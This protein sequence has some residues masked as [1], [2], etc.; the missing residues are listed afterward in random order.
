MKGLAELTRMNDRD[1]ARALKRRYEK[2]RA[3]AIKREDFVRARRYDGYVRDFTKFLSG[4]IEVFPGPRE[5]R[6]GKITPS[7]G[8]DFPIRQEREIVRVV[9]PPEFKERILRLDPSNRTLAEHL[10]AGKP[11][12][13]WFKIRVEPYAD[14]WQ[15]RQLEE[16]LGYYQLLVGSLF[17]R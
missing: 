17:V 13:W 8:R 10:A 12:G 14:Y 2:L 1:A 15:R 11:V 3:R 6:A 4:E 5:H 7:S 16:L 9:Y